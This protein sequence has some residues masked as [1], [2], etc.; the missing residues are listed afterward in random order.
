MHTGPSR[1]FKTKRRI[2]VGD[3]DANGIVR[4]DALARYLQDVGYDDTDDIGVGDGGFWVARSIEM[5]FP[6][7]T[8]MPKRNEW[9]NLETFCGG[10]GRA[11]AE[12]TVNI[13]TNQG[14]IITTNTIWISID[15]T[16]KPVLI[17][18]WLI[19]AYPQAKKINATRTL[20]LL[21]LEEKFDG[22]TFDWEL[23]STDVD[24]NGHINNVLAFIAL[25]EVAQ[26]LDAP[27]PSNVLV[28]YR[29]SLLASDETKIYSRDF[30]EG[31][32]AWL[33]SGN[34]IAATMRW[35]C[36]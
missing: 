21:N 8:K 3:C 4:V 11:F 14:D 9:V 2:R 10:V 27:S 15:K 6:Q 17:P 1:I 32:D 36:R 22:T 30:G 18:K 35:T 31:F 25:Y 5:R 12:R 24:V 23:R 33:V 34:N 29:H 16:G 13:Y 7:K 19:K 26:L 20:P 28:E